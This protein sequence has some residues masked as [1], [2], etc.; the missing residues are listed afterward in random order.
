MDAESS[1][2]YADPDIWRR[3]AAAAA[4]HLPRAGR[5]A[6]WVRCEPG[7]AWRYRIPDF[8]LWAVTSG[9]G[10]A[11][12]AGGSIHLSAG[13]ILMLRPGDEVDVDQDEDD[14]LHV[15]Y[16][17]YDYPTPP[18]AR[19][20][21]PRVV[22]LTEPSAVWQR[23]R[24]VISAIHRRDSS[25]PVQASADLAALLMEVHIQAARSAGAL[26]PPLDP[27]VQLATNMLRSR[28]DQRTTLAE[29]A[30]VAKLAPDTF[31][32]LFHAATGRTFRAYCVAVRIERARE[33]LSETALNVT[34]VAQVLGYTDYRLF[35][36]QFAQH[37]QGCPPSRWRGSNPG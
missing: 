30:A 36:R 3:L 26:P 10:V 9:K 21:A 33:L 24:T 23:L 31:S 14:R 18:A 16:C 32:R 11:R 15:G 6:S 2:D 37:N 8:D 17:H 22:S 25:G 7:W 28:L 1:A 4:T 29:A 13:T 12:L 19:L 35:A 20:L 34:E 27:R 5:F